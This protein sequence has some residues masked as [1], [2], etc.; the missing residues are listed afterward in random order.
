MKILEIENLKKTYANGKVALNG[1]SLSIN[2]GEFVALL[3]P[4]GAGKSTLINIL[5][6]VV[7]KT[8]GKAN[9]CGYDLDSNKLDFK[10]SIGI[11]PQEINFDPFFTPKEVLTFQQGFY[12]VKKDENAILE[13]LENMGLTQQINTNARFLSGGMKR[14]L[15][16]AKALIHNPEV[17]ILDEPTAGVDVELRQHLWTFLKKLNQQGKTIILTTHYL[18]EAEELCDKIAVIN[19]GNLVTYEE[20]NN[21]LNSIGSKTISLQVRHI[22]ENLNFFAGF[23]VK[24]KDNNIIITYKNQ[25]DTA[26]IL[27]LALKNN[28]D[29][30]NVKMEESNL[31]DV[32]LTLVK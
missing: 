16:V 2:K 24:T 14:R 9:V 26:K 32:F 15:L 11:V 19:K 27:A 6:D 25:E 28:L 21:L 1:V 7:I 3:G 23:D 5:S 29:I 31:E 30:I 22:P 17:I 8:S 13:L 10:R 18:E 4:N 20:K 12:G